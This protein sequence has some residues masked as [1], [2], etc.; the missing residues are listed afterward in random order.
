MTDNKI[1]KEGRIG[2]A[3]KQLILNAAEFEFAKHGFKGTRIQQVADR[4]CLPKTNV[5]YYFKSKEN[6]YL[7]VLQ[8]ILDE[9]NSVF[10][11]A[12]K[13]DDP[14]EVLAKY[15]A[16]KMEFSLTRPDASRIFALEIINGAPNLKGF[17]KENNVAWMEGRVEVVQYW[18]ETGK[19]QT[20]NAYYLLY[21]IWACCQHYADFSAQITHLQGKQMGE[22][23]FEE[24]TKAII[25]LVLKGCSLEIPEKYR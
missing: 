4:A 16:E 6:L 23:E 13:E 9:W 21:H 15:I 8:Q 19:I 12:T 7:A 11:H 24:A 20:P 17:Y 22:S 10:D 25:S 18:I 1:N 14:A 3:N 2:A 5:L